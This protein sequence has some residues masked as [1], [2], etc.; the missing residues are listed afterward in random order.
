MALKPI[1]V[2]QLNE[3]LD[4]IVKNDPIMSNVVIK[5]ELSGVKYHASGHIYFSLVDSGSRLN[6]FYRS[7]L[8]PNLKEKLSDGMEVTCTGRIGIYTGGGSYSLYVNNLEIQGTGFLSA[9]FERLKAKLNS[10]GIFDSK[11]KKKLPMFPAKV[12]VITASTGAAIRD[13][14]KTIK[15]RNDVCDILIFPS[16]V[17]GKGAGNEIARRIQY[18]NENHSDIDVLIVGRGGGSAEDLWAFNEEIVARAIFSSKI[19]IVSA[20]GHEVDFSISDLAADVRAATPTAAGQIVVPDTGELAEKI[21][22]IKYQLLNQLKNN[23]S[24]N[25][26]KANN[27]L[28]E[29]R[30]YIRLDISEKVSQINQFKTVLEGNDPRRILKNGYAILED[31]GGNVVAGIGD[32]V[33][34]N[35]YKVTLSDGSGLMEFIEEVNSHEG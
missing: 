16:P 20:V 31:S 21:Q 28:S 34:N 35:C 15:S 3:Y 1:T 27:I 30:N 12:G 5:G 19:P 9:E 7:R 33:Q 25:I 13:I 6:C 23:V 29:M 2:T 22:D 32:M 26:L 14:T 24:F 10:E 17:Q 11:H 18:V 4:R 8:V